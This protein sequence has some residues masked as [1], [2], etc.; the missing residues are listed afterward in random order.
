[1]VEPST[2]TG[3]TMRATGEPM[4]VCR[5]SWMLVGVSGAP[6]TVHSAPEVKS[7]SCRP[8]NK[9]RM[10]FTWSDITPNAIA[11]SSSPVP[12]SKLNRSPVRD[13]QSRFGRSREPPMTRR[14]WW[15]QT[16]TGQPWTGE[17]ASSSQSVVA[18]LLVSVS[19]TVALA[20]WGEATLSM[21]NRFA[22]M[23]NSTPACAAWNTAEE[24]VIV[25]LPVV[26]V[27]ASVTPLP[28][29][30]WKG[31][32]LK[33]Q[34]AMLQSVL[35]LRVTR[36]GRIPGWQSSSV[37]ALCVQASCGSIAAV[38]GPAT[39]ATCTSPTKTLSSPSVSTSR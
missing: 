34:A 5:F 30:R 26:P 24:A 7:C 17:K 16:V 3:W 20:C 21:R 33:L 15:K 1:M 32:V 22:A 14:F 29:K 19:I 6:L 31:G 37:S 28:A 10:A 27:A 11:W 18:A 8:E 36:C 12:G 9:P 4:R 39:C 25:T 2:S 35:L 38:Q 23:R 13:S